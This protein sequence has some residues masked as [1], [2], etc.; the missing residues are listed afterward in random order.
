[1][2]HKKEFIQMI[3]KTTQTQTRLLSMRVVPFFFRSMYYNYYLYDLKH[4][5]QI[6]YVHYLLNQLKKTK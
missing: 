1:M 5:S 6:E 2:V 4:T 3:Q